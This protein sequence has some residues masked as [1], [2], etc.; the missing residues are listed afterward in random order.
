MQKRINTKQ[1][2]RLLIRDLNMGF[3]AKSCFF[4]VFIIATFVETNAFSTLLRQGRKHGFFYFGSTVGDYVMYVLRGM[5]VYTF[6]PENYF[7]IPIIWFLF[8]IGMVYMTVYYANYDMKKY[9][10]QILPLIKRRKDWWTS[11]CIWCFCV[12]VFSYILIVF[13]SAVIAILNGAEWTLVATDEKLTNLYSVYLLYVSKFDLFVSVFVVPVLVTYGHC[14]FFMLIGLVLSPV[15]G[16]ALACSYYVLA[17]YTTVWWLPI[18]YTM[19]LRSA[20]VSDKGLVSNNGLL[21]AGLFCCLSI[22][23]GYEHIKKKDFY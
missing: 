16:F 9:G 21:F 15:I 20:Y 4:I 10:R 13:T 6:R 1:K 22:L 12:V 14:L 2:N 7:T 19:W 8:Q 18:N 17:A 11:K 3:R 23:W 5:E